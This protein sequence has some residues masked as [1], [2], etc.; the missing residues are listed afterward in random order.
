MTRQQRRATERRAEKPE[1]ATVER[2]SCRHLGRT[3][4]QPFSRMRL[5][6]IIP[7][8]PGKP[9][10]F[11]VRG[12]TTNKSHSIKATFENIDWFV[13]GITDDMKMTMLG[14]MGVA[15]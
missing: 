8:E 6:E 15:A 4:G 7:A 12:Y 10:V 5:D 14:R 1:P 13:N 11:N 9:A 3:K 2:T